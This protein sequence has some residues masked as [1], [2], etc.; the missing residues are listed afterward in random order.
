MVYFI[1]YSP[2]LMFQIG[3][4]MT[5]LEAPVGILPTTSGC[6]SILNF[7]KVVTSSEPSRNTQIATDITQM[8]ANFKQPSQFE[9]I[10][11]RS[12][13]QHPSSCI[14]LHK[15]KEKRID[16]FV[17]QF[18]FFYQDFFSFNNDRDETCFF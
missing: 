10:S 6:R 8:T 3:I 11:K 4:Q 1:I 16:R 18:L 14:S 12:S 2:P 17:F 13:I 9:S 15:N 7:T 5:S